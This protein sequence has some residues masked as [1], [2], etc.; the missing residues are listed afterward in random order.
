MNRKALILV[1]MSVILAGLIFGLGGVMRDKPGQ[2][3]PKLSTEELWKKVAAAEKDGLPQTAIE[4][5]KAI[6]GMALDQNRESEALKALSRQL[7]LESVIEGNRPEIR[8]IRVQEEIAKAPAGM[9]T[10]LRVILAQWYRHYHARN[11]WRFMQ[12]EATAGGI[13]EKDFTTWDLRRL[14]REIDTLYQDILKDEAVLKKTPISVY[15]DFLQPGNQPESLRPTLYDFVVF[16]ALDFYTSGEQAAIAPAD[17]FSIEAASPA[18]GPAAEFLKFEPDTTDVDSP[19]LRALRLYQGL[20]DFHR[21]DKDRD[22]F[23]DADLHRLRTMKNWAA[24]EEASNRYIERLK[25]ISEENSGSVLSA[26]ADYLAAEEILAK[27]DAVSAYA[28]ADRGRKAHP[29]SHGGKNCEALI[30]QITAREYDVRTESVAPAGRP[31]Q[32]AVDYRNIVELHFRVVKEDFDGLL[33][34]KNA[35]AL[36]WARDTHVKN[37]LRL[38]PE[39]E[40]SV[41]LEPTE[42]YQTR[43]E[44]VELPAL[45]PGFYRILAS[46]DKGFGEDDNKI[47]AGSFWASGLGLVLGGPG[48]G[49]EGFVVR[50][51]SGVPVPDAEITLYEWNNRRSALEKRASV[52]TDAQGA[53]AAPAVTPYNSLLIAKDGSGDRLAETSIPRSYRR[54]AEPYRRTVFFTDRSLYRPGQTI[55]FKGLCLSVDE[56]RDDYKIL[57]RQKL[58]V[59]FRDANRQ[60]I[61][62][63]TLVSNDF[64]TVSGAFTAPTGR[65]TGA[66][67][68]SAEDP[69]GSCVIRVEEYVRPKF[70]VKIDVPDREFRLNDNV[71]V[72]GEAMSYAGAP[73]DG[74]LVKYRVVR[75]VRF[76]PWRFFRYGRPPGEGAQEIAHGTTRTDEEGKFV[77]SFKAR[78]DP[79][80]SPESQPVFTFAVTAEVT[81][82]T[83]ETRAAE[84]RIRLGYASLQAE[85]SSADWQETGKPVVLSISARTLSGRP[86]AARGV[87]EVTALR[88]PD[89]PVPS[90]LIGEIAVR[91]RE[92]GPDAPISQ[93]P[94]W[95]NWP[96]GDRTATAEFTM[97]AD[98]EKPVSLSFDLEAG[99][100]K[101]RLQTR[102]KYGTPVENLH[103]FIVLDPSAGTFPIKIPFRAAAKTYSVEPGETFELLWGTGYDR[104]PVL[105]EIYRSGRLV[106]RSWNDPAKTQDVVRIPV[107]EDWRGGF[108]VIATMVKE[109]RL[110][111]EE[112]R[113]AVPWS[114]KRLDLKWLTFRSKLRPGQDETW[115]L[116]IKGPDAEILAAEMVAS[117]YDASLDQFYGHGFPGISG[118]FRREM[119]FGPAVFSNRPLNLRGYIDRLRVGRQ[120]I[121]A[122]YIRLPQDILRD[123]LG[124]EYRMRSMPM[125]IAE[126]EAGIPP[127]EALAVQAE[128][129]P[130]PA[131]AGDVPG[132]PPAR[133]EAPGEKAPEIDLSTVQARK[134]LDETAFFYPHLLTGPDGT[135]TLEF[136]MPEALTEW[137][138]L[139]FAHTRDLLSGLIEARTVTQKELMV[140][141]LPPRFM[142]EGDRLEFT[143]KVTNMTE[144]EANG[145]V[146]LRF[147]DPRN[148]QPLDAAFAHD[149]P[150]QTFSIPAGQSRSFSWPLVVSDGLEAAGFRAVAATEEFSDGEEGMFPV[151]SRRILVRESVPLWISGK[152]EKTFRFDKLAESEASPTLRHLG[153]TVQMASNPA[154]YAVQAL[155]FLMEYPY[156]CSEQ[157]FNRL[158]A[159]LLAAHIAGSDPRIRR[160]FD[161]W[162]GTGALESNLEKNEDLK[163]VLLQES[164]WV[165][166]ARSESQAKRNIGRLFDE[167]LMNRETRGALGK[168]ADMQL[169]DGSW[170]WFPGGPGND[171]ITLYIVTGFGRLKNLGVGGVSQEPAM[172]ALGRLDRWIREIYDRILKNKIEDENNLSPAV[173]LYLYARSF[174]LDDRRIPD[175]SREAV[176]YF[177]AQAAEH[178]LKLASRQSQA[179]L[180]LGLNRMGDAETARK[181]MRSIKERS[182]FDEEMG[183]YWED[184]GFA[185][186]WHRAPIETQAVVIEAFDEVMNDAQAVEESKIWLLKQKQTQDWKTTKATADAV[187]AL[188]LRG[189]DL[190]AS[191]AIVEVALGGKTVEPEKVE[192]GTGF[193]EKRFAGSEVAPAMGDIEVRKS[194]PGIAWGG[195][196]WQYL[197]DISRITP[198]EQNPLTLKK[199]VFVRR[200]T[201]S[202][203]VIEPVRG[204]LAVGDTVVV[205]IELRTDRDMEYVHMRDHRGSGL[206]PVNVLSQYKFQDGL[207]YYEATRDAATHFFIDYLPKGTYVFEYSLRVQHRGVYENGMA[208]I[209]CMY[210]PEFNSH[211]GSVSLE[212]KE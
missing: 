33:S 98:R 175:Q 13:D 145:A 110:Y 1:V 176:D 86:A 203:P 138:F 22:V 113:V 95:R 196:H 52:R 183:R 62:A 167:N 149:A 198:H 74:A 173:A 181:I 43:R 34:G 102:D 14:F 37:W 101:A 166:Q 137:R 141:P 25:E 158:Y 209:E 69:R 57:T 206:E 116:Q 204:P 77:V 185:W 91:E 125:A 194:D 21:K 132:L 59:V 58:R 79:S 156:E 171:F 78:P 88:G 40:W 157:I 165:L 122:S 164:P 161:L 92:A 187:Y 35:D 195:V 211:S 127:E 107:P 82:G 44:I 108:T 119:S 71:D 2:D 50:N 19:K 5:L 118:I 18:L 143:A 136:K 126:D 142:R 80:V 28:L 66:M 49:V 151:L 63:L 67:S 139:G 55:Q 197:E 103:Y 93:T 199:S 60:E 65:L 11:R 174:Y 84:G 26:A 115:S 133:D 20:L 42:D 87:V 128:A 208:H 4:H 53:F 6:V 123:M 45:K 201:R 8:I 10:M 160:I 155:P 16:E 190:L 76:P 97:S 36:F 184:T 186:W 180:A 61:E 134:K 94:D 121:T 27:G 104:G 140:Q 120:F 172:N 90:D 150:K 30:A 15:R 73:I 193:Y 169:N 85:M 202:G 23:L 205:R 112:R 168:L 212:V 182:K 146:E 89:R 72:P 109:N 129:P 130:A 3:K 179:H 32:L 152:G 81:D 124:Y 131:I 105:V 106:R 191:D 54:E 192:A 178:W 17:A 114:N 12:R 96:E 38:K 29:E 47:A 144:K 24:G 135:V 68:I 188:I 210:A 177:L 117:L 148:E 207:F 75:E 162:K 159:N 147:F 31:S 51:Q 39:A 41:R 154:W 189:T 170:P 7:V 46:H 111:R 83:G 48:S 99:A 56:E 163:I 64:G 70:Q 9:K 200:L 153:L 100:Y